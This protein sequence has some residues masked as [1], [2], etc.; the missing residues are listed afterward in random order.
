M[1]RRFQ[2]ILSETQYQFL[3]AEANRSSVSVAELIRRAID[4]TYGPTGEKRVHF[5][6]HTLGRRSGFRVV[7]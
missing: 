2:L 3:S 6:T 1:S 4:G 5:I 7:D